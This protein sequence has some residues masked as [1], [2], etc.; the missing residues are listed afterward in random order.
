MPQN[1]LQH[2]VA[3][4]HS[5]LK[6][7]TRAVSDQRRLSSTE[8]INDPKYNTKSV[9]RKPVSV[10][11]KLVPRNPGTQHRVAGMMYSFPVRTETRNGM[12]TR[13]QKRKNSTIHSRVATLAPIED[14]NLRPAIKKA[15]I[16][17][18]P[19]TDVKVLKDVLAH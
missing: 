19:R 6:T 15:I 1:Y 18:L 2:F 5:F 10:L 14:L 12:A 4:R 7:R 17:L 3:L 16:L 9:D 8:I 13:A 11:L